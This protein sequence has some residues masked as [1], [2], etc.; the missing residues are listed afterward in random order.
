MSKVS[1]LVTCSTETDT[2]ERLLTRI[3][4]VLG[5]DRLIILQDES[6]KSENTYKIIEIYF[7]D[8]RVGLYTHP[9]N[10]DYGGHKNYGIENCKGDWILQIDGDEIPPDAL[11]GENLHALIES[12][13]SIE[14]YAV[15]RINAWD[16]LTPEHATQWGW[17]LDMSP[18]HKRLRASW[19]DYQWRLFKNAP[20][21]RFKNR[22]HER[23]DGFKSYAILP[24]EEEWALY[25][26]KTIE[27]Q[28]KTN[29]RYNEWFTAAE[30][31]GVSNNITY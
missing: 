20:H 22:L 10:K 3:V 5:D 31:A 14:A 8:Y 2:L 6:S 28:I 25:H 16:G 21:I 24:P 13:P 19:P 12:N 17:K 29:I 26:D 11:L 1:Y 27:T 18:T 7:D 30:N 9:L 15:P 23:I 4:A